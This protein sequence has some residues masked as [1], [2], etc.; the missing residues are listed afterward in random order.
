MSPSLRWLWFLTRPEC[1]FQRNETH[2]HRNLTRTVHRQHRCWEPTGGDKTLGW[3]NKLCYMIKWNI[4]HPW[5]G[6]VPRRGWG[7]RSGLSLFGGV[8]M[9]WCRSV[10]KLRAGGC[11][12][13]KTLTV[14]ETPH[15]KLVNCMQSEFYLN[16]RKCP[17]KIMK[18]SS[19]FFTPKC[20]V[21]P[22]SQYLLV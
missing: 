8:L 20:L 22:F 4:I 17:I 21:H 14:T 6:T 18:S 12:I 16:K 9:E 2:A 5:K 10:W 11:K 7:L 3:I 19:F 1:I 13:P 15:Y